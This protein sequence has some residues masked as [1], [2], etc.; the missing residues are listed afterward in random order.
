MV[1]RSASVSFP[2]GVADPGASRAYVRDRSG[3]VMMLDLAT[4][5]VLW[6]A[7]RA[8]RPLAL[9][10]DVLVTARITGAGGIEIVILDRADGAVR[11]V[12]KPFSLPLWVR[13]SLDDSPE[14]GLRAEIDGQSVI[15]RWSAQSRYRGGA[16]PSAQ[17][18]ESYEH[19]A[20]G[21]ARV[22]LETGDVELLDEPID[23]TAV[24]TGQTARSTAEPDVVEQQEIGDKFFQLVAQSGAGDIG[25]VLVR[26][27]ERQSGKTLWETVIEETPLRRPKPLR[28]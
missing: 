21:A 24:S 4:G 3:T 10:D 18:R 8:L 28:P 2:R 17:V 7:G 12:S 19:D 25:K 5:E 15:I 20:Q 9:A 6:R 13:P 14:F 1:E 11:R 23:S 16:P 27:I 22:A 26:A